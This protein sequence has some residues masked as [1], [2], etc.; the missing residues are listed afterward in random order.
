M[1]I[2][3]HRQKLQGTQTIRKE[4]KFLNR[5][6]RIKNRKKNNRLLLAERQVSRHEKIFAL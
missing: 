5:T 6:Q 3:L 4:Q 2:I 1:P